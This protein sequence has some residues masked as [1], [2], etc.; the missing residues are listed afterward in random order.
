MA[1]RGLTQPLF[2][3]EL[4]DVELHAFTVPG[5]MIRGG[6]KAPPMKAASGRRTP[7]LHRFF[8]LALVCK[9]RGDQD[10]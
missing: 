3:E 9:L 5:C 2:E 4:R 7:K 6:V 1:G 8:L 10:S